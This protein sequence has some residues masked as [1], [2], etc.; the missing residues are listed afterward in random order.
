M[1]F[2]FDLDHTVI[3]SSHRQATLPNGDLDLAHW[4]ENAT[5][6]MI[7][8][9]SLLPLAAEWRKARN[10]GAEIV[11]CT[12]RTMQL[13]D[14]YYLRDHGLEYDAMLSRP[15][16]N[17]ITD[18][19]L[20]YLSLYHYATRVKEQRWKTFCAFSIMFDD[21]KNVIEGLN[22]KGLRVYNALEINKRLA[23]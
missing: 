14:F 2:I 12:A 20:K 1:R 10:A 6:E 4:F 21:N 5:P 16:G 8:K 3:D 23:A 22:R 19:A 7:A 15:E 17:M 13:A 9:D 11:V 18:A